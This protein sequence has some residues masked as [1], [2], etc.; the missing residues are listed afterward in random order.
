[1]VAAGAPT[2]FLGNGRVAMKKDALPGKMVTLG[3]TCSNKRK[4]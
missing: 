1:M 2:P 4:P 3:L